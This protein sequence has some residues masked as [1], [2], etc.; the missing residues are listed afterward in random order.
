[1]TEPDSIADRR[2]DLTARLPEQV[3]RKPE[4]LAFAFSDSAVLTAPEGWQVLKS[5]A[6]HF[7]DE[8]ICGVVVE[9]LAAATTSSTVPRLSIAPEATREVY[10]NWLDHEEAGTQSPLYIEARIIAFTG[11]TGKWGIWIDQDRELAVL[12]APIASLALITASSQSAFPWV[13]SRA[14]G[15]ILAPSFYPATVPLELLDRLNRT[16]GDS[17]GNA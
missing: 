17:C 11:S 16:Y 1:M 6:Q 13:S 9:G 4:D 8:K 15:D 5:C 10:I 7:G 2:F 3:F 12:G 14:V